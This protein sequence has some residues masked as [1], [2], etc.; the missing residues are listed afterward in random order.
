MPS[1]TQHKLQPPESYESISRQQDLDLLQSDQ[2]GYGT[3]NIIEVSFNMVNATV[4]A[5]VIGLP[6]A[7]LLAGFINGVILSVI[8]GFLTFAAVYAMIL[9][10]QRLGVYKFAALG[11]H[12][13]GRFGFH[14][15]NLM[16]FIQSAGSCIS[17]FILV[18]DTLPILLKLYLPDNYTFFSNRELVT[19]VIAV[20]VIFP[21][22]LPRSIGA[23]ASWSTVSVLLLPV[24]ILS[25]L[26]RA[27]AYSKLHE[28]PLTMWGTD[29]VSAIG[30]MSF[31][32][33]C[34]QV[35]FNNYLSQ[36]NQSSTAWGCT[37]GL[38]VF[39]S[40]CVSI[41]FAI[42]GYLSFGKDVESNIFA[43][44][45]ENDNV[46]NVGRLS[47]GLSMVL[48]VPMAFYPARDA[49]QKSLGFETSE[50]QPTAIQHYGVSVV[51]FVV[52]LFFGV[53]VRS[54]GKVYSVV[55]GFASAYLAYIMPAL[56]YIGAFHPN[57]LPWNRGEAIA[58]IIRE[59]QPLLPKDGDTATL[60]LP[61]R[62]RWLDI[63]SV[64]LLGFGSLVM[65][66]TAI[67]AFN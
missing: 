36:R 31:A 61:K 23:L 18:A 55:G 42:I 22:N 38:S 24:M 33:V 37:S 43:N 45:P 28:A 27:P 29:P 2:P 34:S 4:G 3:R 16:L 40:W 62:K 9:A 66:F 53:S 12:V 59:G 39:L 60:V 35:A 5:G 13:M 21:L 11:E 49:V 51:L 52:F 7:L 46:I 58:D 30:I 8:V 17:Y 14:T 50:K 57:W 44:F 48:T 56:A 25:V 41:T 15:L 32:L 20:F 63:S 6:L 1:E 54:L 64:I 19:A 65:V 10:G 47:L 26:I 67:K